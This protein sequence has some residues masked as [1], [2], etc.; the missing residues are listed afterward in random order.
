MT[1]EFQGWPKIARLN[2]DMIVTEKIDGTN[3]AV[4]I[5]RCDEMC[6][7]NFGVSSLVD[8]LWYHVAAQSR[9]QLLGPSKDNFGFGAWVERN[10]DELVRLLGEGR[11]FGEWWGSGIQR[12]Y[13]LPKGEKRFS[14]FNTRKHAGI[15]GRG[16]L[17][18][19]V[20]HVPVVHAGNFST[21]RVMYLLNELEV[22]GSAAA[23][24]FMRPEG[25]IVYHVAA[26][27]MFKVT[28]EDD[29]SPKGMV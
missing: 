14:L 26:G 18:I 23:P 28:I 4:V 7:G 8:G 11:H 2:R 16:G 5:E 19:G 15:A 29:A 10:A 12:G 17:D 13:G 22:N 3:G 6:D 27:Q 24:G 9:K 21:P 1:I 25:V 20:D